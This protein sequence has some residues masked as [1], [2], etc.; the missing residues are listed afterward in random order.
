[1]CSL[2]SFLLALACAGVAAPGE[3]AG[4]SEKDCV[5]F[6]EGG[7]TAALPCLSSSLVGIASTWLSGDLRMSRNNAVVRGIPTS[8]AEVL[9]SQ[10]CLS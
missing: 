2:V 5:P 1:M 3:G 8:S 4:S 6:S 7:L 10:A 9:V